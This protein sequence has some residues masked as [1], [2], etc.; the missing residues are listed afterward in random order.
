MRF[1]DHVDVITDHI[2]PGGGAP[3]TAPLRGLEKPRLGKVP[4]L[5]TA[6]KMTLYAHR[7]D[8]SQPKK[9]FTPPNLS[10]PMSL[11]KERAADIT[12]ARAAR[13]IAQADFLLLAAG[14]GMSAD[15]GLPV[16]L[17]CARFPAYEAAGIDYG[18]LCR[19]TL[20]DD[21]PALFYGFWG[22]CAHDYART[23]PHGGYATLRRWAIRPRVMGAMGASGA[24]SV[25][26]AASSVVPS[27]VASSVA[28]SA[29]ASIAPSFVYTSNV[30]AHFR[31]AG[32]D[33]DRVY[34]LHGS[35]ETWQ[36]RRGVA[37]AGADEAVGGGC[38]GI[39]DEGG[40]CGHTWSLPE[41]TR[42]A[43]DDT[44]RRAA[45]S[46]GTPSDPSFPLLI[47]CTVASAAG[48]T[49]GRAGGRAGG[50][51]AQSATPLRC[52]AC[53][54]RPRPAVLMFED[55]NW[56][57]NKE[58]E[59]RYVAW[60]EQ[61]EGE[62]AR[63]T[64][65]AST[66]KRGGSVVAA[67]ANNG[68]NAGSCGEKVELEPHAPSAPRRVVI[69]EIGCGLRVPCVRQETELVVEDTLA[70]CRQQL[71]VSSTPTTTLTSTGCSA[72]SPSMSTISVMYL[73]LVQMTPP[74]PA[75]SRRQLSQEKYRC[76]GGRSSDGWWHLLQRAHRRVH[77][78]P[79]RKG[80]WLLLLWL[81]ARREVP[82]QLARAGIRH[83]PRPPP[84]LTAVR[85]GSAP[86]KRTQMRIPLNVVAR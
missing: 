7:P 81:L 51:D 30:D 57:G 54:G 11:A 14:A 64:R 34:E 4:H 32:F 55:T 44:T 29:A 8:L 20:V 84:R 80:L 47:Q 61:M 59:A 66:T 17:D 46:E 16:Y 52:P 71:M 70:R 53:G 67:A 1:S 33:G 12:I 49:D 9:P 10:A 6:D 74:N 73:H 76:M 40:G 22:R 58:A 24:G 72:R 19:P 48:G 13:A 85:A 69:V 78:L 39:R 82:T 65:T 25:A 28:P 41:G 83:L 63:T 23:D 15:S 31:R 77:F 35:C 42:V 43:V 56:A 18:D 75:R 26:V 60:E 68:E 5:S 37:G 62:M 3:T 2:V 79:R 38:E 50:E 45:M 21:D 36:C 27:L 86:T